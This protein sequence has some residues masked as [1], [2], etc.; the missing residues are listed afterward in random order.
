MR[1]LVSAKPDERALSIAKRVEEVL[2]R[3]GI[4]PCSLEECSPCSVDAIVVVGGDG[5]L[6]YTLSK[7]SCKTPPVIT[8]RAGRRAFLL[9]LEPE[10]FEGALK[11][12]LEGDYFEEVHKRLDVE[13][14]YALNE[15]AV[16]SKWRRVTRVNVSA[17]GYKVYEG[18]E[19]DGVIISTTVGS[20]AYALSAGGPLVDPRTEVLLVVPVNPIQLNARSIVLPS[21][22]KVR[23]EVT[24]NREETIVL[25][26][27]IIEL[28]DKDL[29]ITLNGP[30]VTFA[31]FKIREFYTKLI[32]LRSFFSK[33]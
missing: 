23:V 27:G 32:E 25:A 17:D 20:T 19:G 21:T 9:D 6:L 7:A 24:R 33:D 4:S 22:S 30:E 13:G 16:L 14:I 3:E 15:V 5:T 31:R 26:D 12:F 11:R 1:A 10:E 8:V 18:L 28:E 29:N 2:R